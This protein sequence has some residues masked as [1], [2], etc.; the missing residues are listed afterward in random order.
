MNERAG[1]AALGRG[2]D[3]AIA[4]TAAR[5]AIRYA[6]RRSALALAQSRAFIATLVAAHPSLEVEEVQIVTSGDKHTDKPLQDL[7]GK[8][9]FI[10]VLEEALYEGRA[11]LAVHSFKDVPADLPPGLEIACVPERADP[12]DALV[13]RDGATLALLKAGARIGTSSLR[14]AVCIRAARPDLV[15]EPLRGNVD[16]RLRKV[17][18]GTLDAAVLAAAGLGRLGLAHRITDALSTDQCLPAIAQGALAIEVRVDDATVR[19]LLA[20]L[21]HAETAIAV[22]AER[23]FMGAMGGNCRMPIACHARRAGD[24]MRLEGLVA[25]SDGSRLRRAAREVGWP[26]SR[27]DS[28]RAGLELAE[29]L[30]L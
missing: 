1:G 28:V 2:A 27:E 7:G 9:L 30:R 16:T 14:R 29:A 25:E 10:K 19:A 18:E 11:D 5:G 3:R 8:G 26:A 22:A 4:S 17:D 12:R 24:A 20:P 6:T 23:A 15:V 13:A 21:E